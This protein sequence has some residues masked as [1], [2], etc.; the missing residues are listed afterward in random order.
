MG[1]IILGLVIRQFA[2]MQVERLFAVQRVFL[3]RFGRR[4]VLAERILGRFALAGA[5]FS[6]NIGQFGIFQLLIIVPQRF[7]EHHPAVAIA[8]GVEQFHIDARAVIAD[9]IQ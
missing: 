4:I 7:Q 9:A 3:R 5:L 1:F 6:G 8:D 2:A